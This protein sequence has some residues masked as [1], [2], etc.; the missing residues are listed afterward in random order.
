[1]RVNPKLLTDNP[2]SVVRDPDIDI[3]VELMGGLKPTKALVQE[4]LRRRKYVVT[5]NK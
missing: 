2:F 3:V 1:V 5:A 4:A